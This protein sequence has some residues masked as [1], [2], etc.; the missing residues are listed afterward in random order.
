M[1]IGVGAE[2]I[3]FTEDTTKTSSQQY[4]VLKILI[5]THTKIIPHICAYTRLAG[6][7]HIG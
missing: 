7:K 4:V 6:Y 3:D 2:D 1:F 5:H